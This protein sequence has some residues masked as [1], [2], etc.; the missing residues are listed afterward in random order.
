MRAY[1]EFLAGSADV[2]S[3]EDCSSAEEYAAQFP[4]GSFPAARTYYH[5]CRNR[6]RH[7]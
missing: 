4:N 6:E 3:P 1:E 7:D 5:N 2:K